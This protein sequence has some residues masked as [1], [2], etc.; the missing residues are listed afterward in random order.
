[1]PLIRIEEITPDVRLGLWHITETQSVLLD[2]YSCL[3]VYKPIVDRYKSGTRRIEYLAARALL[4][5][6]EGD[7]VEISHD[8]NGKP[9]LSNGSEISI[10]H[11]RGYVA[12]VISRNMRVAVDIEYLGSRVNR[13]ASRF[14]R[15]DESAVSL[16]EQLLCWCAK[17]T[18]YKLFSSDSLGFQDIRIASFP[19]KRNTGTVSVENLKRNITFSVHYELTDFFMLTY[20]VCDNRLIDKNNIV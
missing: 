5:S 6:M 17:E 9:L 8:D 19:L 16:Y 2:L 15:N 12:I 20:A 10:S 11:T 7:D 18:A 13:V 3:L 14:L 1:M 4:Y